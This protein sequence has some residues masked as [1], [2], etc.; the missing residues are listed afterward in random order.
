MQ[1][2]ITETTPQQLNYLVAQCEGYICQF[3]DE[4]SGPWLVP[5]EGYLHDEKPLSSFSPTTNWAQ[6]GPIIEREKIDISHWVSGNLWHAACPGRMRYDS[7][8]G[9]Y[10]EGSDGHSDG[11]T[12]LIAAMRCF[13]ASRLGIEVDV[14]DALV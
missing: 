3:D 5:Q 8:D 1:I 10:I 14:P 12:P 9:E 7:N 4:A 11:V 2:M 6:G 13:I